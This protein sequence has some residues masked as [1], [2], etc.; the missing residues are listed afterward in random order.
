MTNKCIEQDLEVK[1]LKTDVGLTKIAFK[2][3]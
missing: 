2:R 1:A 3:I